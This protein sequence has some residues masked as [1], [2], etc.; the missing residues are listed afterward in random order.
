MR[1]E[2]YLEHNISQ[3]VKTEQD[4]DQVY[5]QNGLKMIKCKYMS[6]HQI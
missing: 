5:F 4:N 6:G 1:K 2:D 3:K